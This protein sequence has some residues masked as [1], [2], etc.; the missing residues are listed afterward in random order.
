MIPSPSIRPGA[1]C[2]RPAQWSPNARA[3]CRTA[4]AASSRRPPEADAHHGRPDDG[5]AAAASLVLVFRII[6]LFEG[7]RPARL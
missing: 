4:A 2:A 3:T 6:T 1:T 5:G 7:A